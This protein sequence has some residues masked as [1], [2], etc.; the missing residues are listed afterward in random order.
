MDRDEGK[1]IVLIG[2]RCTGKTAVGKKLAERLKM[3]FYDTDDLIQKEA[4]MTIQEL[5]DKKGWPSFREKEKDVI[6]R[7]S[8]LT[9]SIIA[10]GGGAIRDKDNAANLKRNGMIVWLTADV[11]TIIARMGIDPLSSGQRPSLTGGTPAEE[12]ADVLQERLPDYQ[13]LAD[14]SIDTSTIGIDTVVNRIIELI[15]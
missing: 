7:L 12:V 10:T 8:A 11:E 1:N 9:G 3:P 2:Y 6:K 13:R 4:G 14:I 15:Q 5:V